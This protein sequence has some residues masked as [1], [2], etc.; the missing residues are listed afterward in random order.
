MLSYRNFYFTYIYRLGSKLV[1][2]QNK[3]STKPVVNQEDYCFGGNL[4]VLCK[5]NNNLSC[6]L[7][8]ITAITVIK[9]SI[10][11]VANDIR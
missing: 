8:D 9:R 7:F 4:S 2:Y 3:N 10:N 1:Q 11:E 6:H 5:K